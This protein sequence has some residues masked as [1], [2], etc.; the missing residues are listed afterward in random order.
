MSNFSNFIPCIHGGLASTCRYCSGSEKLK[1][2]HNTDTG[3]WEMYGFV[4]GRLPVR[5]KWI[6]ISF[7]Q[8]SQMLASGKFVR[9]DYVKEQENQHA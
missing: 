1:L 8:A 9:V 3:N 6:T 7:D 5:W 4:R 2:R